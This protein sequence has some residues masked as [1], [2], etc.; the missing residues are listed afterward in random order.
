MEKH[1]TLNTLLSSLFTNNILKHWTIFEEKSGS[2]LVKLRFTNIEDINGTINNEIID[3]SPIAFRRKSTKQ[4]NRDRDRAARHKDAR[5]GVHT[6][7]MESVEQPRSAEPDVLSSTAPLDLSAVSLDTS[8]TTPDCSAMRCKSTSSD[9]NMD[10][11]VREISLDSSRDLLNDTY[12]LTDSEN[13]PQ[14]VLCSDT[15]YSNRHSD[16]DSSD[17]PPVPLLPPKAD[18]RDM[19]R[20]YRCLQPN[21]FYGGHGKSYEIKDGNIVLVPLDPPDP[22]V[23]RC[24]ACPGTPLHVC[25][26]CHSRGRHTGHSPWLRIV[27]LDNID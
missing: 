7:S 26:N 5:A 15:S 24:A 19:S 11:L 9:M 23:F 18:S 1:R 16:S 3:Q 13:V 8:T 4:V 12:T 25:K 14:V 6:R 22:I 17:M 21:C 27:N 20:K 2:I 10:F